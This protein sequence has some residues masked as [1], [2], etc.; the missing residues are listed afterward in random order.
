MPTQTDMITPNDSCHPHEYKVPSI[1][2]FVNSL[3]M[4]PILNEA[5]I[6]THYITLNIMTLYTLLGNDSLNA[7][8][9]EPTCA[10]IERL[11]LGYTSVDT[12][13]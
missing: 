10:I 6:E 1:S 5:S 11:L 7:F 4:N 2:Y 3:N 9:D 12:P 13:P 8:T